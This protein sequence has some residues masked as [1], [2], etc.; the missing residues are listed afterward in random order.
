M[1]KTFFL[2]AAAFCLSVMSVS[3]VAFAAEK[4]PQIANEPMWDT[5]PPPANYDPALKKVLDTKAPKDKR[6]SA[7]ANPIIVIDPGHGGSDPGAIGN[8]LQEKNIT[9]DIALKSR[10]YLLANYPVTVYM[11]RS[12]DTTVSLENRVALANN[13]G[14]DFFVSMHINSYTDPA[15]SGLETYHYYG[16]VNGTRLATDIYNKLKNSYSV[17]RGVKEAGFYVLKYTNMP[18][19]LGET[20]FITNPTDAANLANSN[21][22]QTLA[23]QYAQGMHV[24]WWGF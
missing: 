5:A 19:S 11:T 10:A 16:S 13:V 9:L 21:F 3:P 7:L 12:S 24:Y 20:G 4:G 1:K 17:L 23:T 6:A 8:N 18:A 15:A 14:A 2:L 22:R